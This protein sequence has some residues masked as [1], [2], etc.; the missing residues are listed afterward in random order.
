[1]NEQQIEHTKSEI[2][3]YNQDINELWYKINRSGL[4]AFCGTGLAIAIFAIDNELTNEILEN[5]IGV[6]SAASVVYNA[7]S[8]VKRI[9]RR[10]S[11]QQTVRYLEHELAMDEL[12]DDEKPKQY[13]KKT[14]IESR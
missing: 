2:K 7:T 6:M 14:N 12:S 1:M 10:E 9:V 3:K 5:F 11:L 4:F 13:V 8:A